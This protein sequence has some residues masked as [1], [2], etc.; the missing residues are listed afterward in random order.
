MNTYIQDIVAQYSQAILGE[1]EVTKVHE[2]LETYLIDISHLL[3]IH[4]YL[5]GDTP[6]SLD[7]YVCGYLAPIY[8]FNFPDKTLK[9]ILLK[10]DVVLKYL[11]NY[12][13]HYGIKVASEPVP[14]T[15]QNVD[16]NDRASLGLLATAGFVAMSLMIGYAIMNDVFKIK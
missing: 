13:K 7:A 1:S 6:S 2:T 14:R 5:L 3:S 16:E 8:A 4:K 11:G 15:I 12:L 10:Y 9:S